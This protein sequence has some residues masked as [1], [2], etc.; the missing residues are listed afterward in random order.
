MGQQQD[1][2]NSKM[3]TKI[4]GAGSRVV[5]APGATKKKFLLNEQPQKPGAEMSSSSPKLG[6]WVTQSRNV[7]SGDSIKSKTIEQRES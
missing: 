7:I 2:D 5:M 3:G 4:Q 1:Q 6:K